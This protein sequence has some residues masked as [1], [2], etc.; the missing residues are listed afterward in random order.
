MEPTNDYHDDEIN[1]WELHYN[2]V[3]DKWE[4]INPMYRHLENKRVVV[5]AFTSYDEARLFC[6][7]RNSPNE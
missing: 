5:Q 1:G 4:V 2:I 3:E 6:L 7:M